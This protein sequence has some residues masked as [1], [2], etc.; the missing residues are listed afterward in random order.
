MENLEKTIEFGLDNFQRLIGDLIRL[1]RKIFK[2]FHGKNP[3]EILIPPTS[4]TPGKRA[5]NQLRQYKTL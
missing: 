1:S 3:P 5:R 2:P 4:L